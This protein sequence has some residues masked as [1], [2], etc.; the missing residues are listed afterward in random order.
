[1]VPRID[2]DCTQLAHILSPGHR[3]EIIVDGSDL[4]LSEFY[5]A[6]LQILR[7]A[8]DW[9][10]ESM[11]DLQWMVDDMERLYFSPDTGR[12]VTFLPLEDEPKAQ[13]ATIQVFRQNWESV[14]SHQQRL[15]KALLAHITRTQEAVESLKDGVSSACLSVT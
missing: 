5:P 10:Q 3:R 2:F 12:F 8:A 15:G 4:R 14:R 9:I 13:E 6:V 11:D 7:I 1:M